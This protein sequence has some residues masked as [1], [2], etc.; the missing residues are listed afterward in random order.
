MSP[1]SLQ[2][3]VLTVSATGLLGAASLAALGDEH[4]PAWAQG[5]SADMADSP[6]SPHATP[7]TTTPREEIPLDHLRMPDGFNAEI[8]AHGMP[9]ARMMALGTKA[10]CSSAPA[11]SGVSM[12]CATTA[13]SG[14]TSLSPRA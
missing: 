3:F 1:S 4:E 11:V 13:T 7:L 9:G 2:R 6:L 12:R 8:W 14:N 5:R 10:R